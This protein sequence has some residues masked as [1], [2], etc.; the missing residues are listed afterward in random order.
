MENGL[1]PESAPLNPH[2]IKTMQNDIK[3]PVIGPIMWRGF[4]QKQSHHFSSFL[5]MK[6]SSKYTN[7]V[8][9]KLV[10]PIR[11]TTSEISKL[12]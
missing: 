11:I 8:Y 5:S 1:R 4:T 3:K 6:R 7:L 9:F 10:T 2:K 12:R